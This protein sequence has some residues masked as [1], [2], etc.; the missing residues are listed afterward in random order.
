MRPAIVLSGHTAALG[1]VRSLGKMDVPVVLVHYGE[2]DFAGRSKYVHE[3][4]QAPNPES[5][6]DAFIAFLVDTAVRFP[7]AVLIPATDET[8]VAV[9][10][11]EKVLGQYYRLACTDWEVTQ[12]FIDKQFTYALAEHCGVPAPRTLVPH[13]LE[14]A[15]SG[16]KTLGLPCLVKPCQ[17]HLYFERFGKKMLRADSLGQLEEAFTLAMEAGIEVMLQELIPGDDRNVVNYNS[18]MWNGEAL[19]E[20]TAVH[21]RNGPAWFGPPRVVV[22]RHVPE[23]IE[24][25]RRIL[26]EMGFSGYSCIEF[27]RDA[28]DGVYKVLDVNGRHNLSTLLAVRCGINFPWLHYRHL[29]DGIIPQPSDY[30]KEIYWIDLFRDIGYTAKFITKERQSLWDYL[31]PYVKPH[32]FA[33]IDVSDMGP[34]LRRVL[35]YKAKN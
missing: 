2:H 3:T 12:R 19:A 16:A 34:F 30:R 7:G 17:V 29:S 32:V 9:S 25:G 8:I 24:P 26:R 10:R 18:Y 14:E 13:T 28:R 6:E 11:H 4:L 33:I 27:K 23:V 20:F 21:I 35:S 1:V 15:R 31:Q 22:S 5:S